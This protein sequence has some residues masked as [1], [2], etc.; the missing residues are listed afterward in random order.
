MKK[1]SDKFVIEPS[2]L[3]HQNKFYKLMVEYLGE[4]IFVADGKG[5]VIFV[6][7][8]SAKII[9]LPVEQIVGKNAADLEREGYLSTSC[10]MAVLKQRKIVNILQKLKDGRTVLATGVPIFDDDQEEIIMVISTSKD[11]DAVNE[12]LAAV[13]DKEK[14]IQ[15]KNAEIEKLREDAFVEEGLVSI[16]PVMEVI[17]N[18]ILRIAPLGVTVLVEGETGVGKE[19]VARALHRF[20][21]RYK[22]PFIKI[23]CGIIP[24]NL[25]ESELFGYEPG[26]FTGA[27]KEGKPGKV[28]MADGGTLFLDEIGEMPLPLQVKLLDFIQD[29]T[30]T[31]VGGI[32]K[33]KVDVRIIA[34]TNRDLKSMS[35]KGFFRRDLYYRLNV[36]PI[37]IPALRERPE[38]IGVL[39][40]YFISNYNVKYKTHKTLDR[41]AKD[42]LRGYSWPG[43][44][45]ELEHVLERAF[46]MADGNLIQEDALL[47]ILYGSVNE[48]ARDERKVICMDIIPLKDAKNEVEKQLIERAS[49]IYG[50]TYKMADALQID[51]STVVKLMKKHRKE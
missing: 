43:N 18:A 33:R 48:Q 5:N 42:V 1:D 36:I 21:E 29:G 24:E 30:F 25:I 13:E 22:K 35:E 51:Q 31:P 8:A 41:K 39:A 9:G 2:L 20:S 46:I 44:V 50:S 28:E 14:E 7:P 6:N 47:A 12:L 17:R 40:K 4:E 11:V 32:Q 19:L 37:K 23:N 16:D 26:A 34:A 15:M 10:T 3:K 45:R 27:H 38:D 49:E